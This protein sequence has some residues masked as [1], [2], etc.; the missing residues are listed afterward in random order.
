MSNSKLWVKQD[1][2]TNFYGDAK[3]SVV[4]G[5]I[6]KYSVYAICSDASSSID[7]YFNGLSNSSASITIVGGGS[8][9]KCVLT[10]P[11]DISNRYWTAHA[12]R[13]L[14]NR[15][16]TCSNTANNQLTCTRFNTST[17][18]GFGGDI[19]VLVF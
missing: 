4:N 18:V 14:G 6:M 16:V 12:V 8:A 2:S 15:G 9:G 3:Q 11:S 19:T 1:G 10:F 13:D 7:R 17:G 5:G